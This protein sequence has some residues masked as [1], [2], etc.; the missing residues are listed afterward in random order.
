[1]IYRFVTHKDINALIL[2][3]LLLPAIA[4]NKDNELKRAEQ[5]ALST[6]ISMLNR[7]LE[8]MQE[9][10][11]IVAWDPDT[12][13]EPDTYVYHEWIITEGTG[14][15]AVEIPRT[16]FFISGAA[17]VPG[18]EPQ[19][20]P[21]NWT[22]EDPRHPLLVQHCVSLTVYN[23]IRSVNNTMMPKHIIEA[24][25]EAMAWLENVRTGI[26]NPILPEKSEGNETIQYGFLSPNDFLV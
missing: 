7:R 4:D 8:I 10:I 23:A 16:G 9:L 18:T 25:K 20:D 3:E 15:E 14:T 19:D 5:Q 13:Y 1:M 6:I 12:D 21:D 17:A 22:E 11:E 26:D 2:D 24:R